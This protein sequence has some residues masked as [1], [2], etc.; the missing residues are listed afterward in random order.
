[1]VATNGGIRVYDLRA[2]LANRER[3]LAS[4]ASTAAISPK[5]SINPSNEVQN[6]GDV[7]NQK[8]SS[9]MRYKMFHTYTSFLQSVPLI[10]SSI[11]HLDYFLEYV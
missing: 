2:L 5:T 8:V 1:M 6:S 7:G 11:I 3:M 4:L 10:L 9:E